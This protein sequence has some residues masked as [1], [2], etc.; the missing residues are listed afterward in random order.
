MHVR[1]EKERKKSKKRSGGQDV[2]DHLGSTQ[3][4]GVREELVELSQRCP[5]IPPPVTMEG[6]S[7]GREQWSM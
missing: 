5:Q 4:G 1:I 2:V 6:S 7:G 3:T